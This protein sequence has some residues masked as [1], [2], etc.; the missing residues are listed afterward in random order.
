MSPIADSPMYSTSKGSGLGFL[1]RPV[2]CFVEPPF[3][4]NSDVGQAAALGLEKKATPGVFVHMET[5]Q[6]VDESV[7]NTRRLSARRSGR[8]T[9][10]TKKQR[11]RLSVDTNLADRTERE[12]QDGHTLNKGL[13][14]ECS[15]GKGEEVDLGDEKPFK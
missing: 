3:F 4:K 7:S 2:C 15:S 9:F 11:V 8:P 12:S 1:S 13:G 10:D 5:H 14:F 6:A